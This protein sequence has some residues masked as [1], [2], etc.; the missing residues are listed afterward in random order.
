MNTINQPETLEKGICVLVDGGCLNNNKPVSERSMYGSMTVFYNGKQVASRYFV[1]I[2]HIEEMFGEGDPK[3]IHT[4]DITGDN[5]SNNYAEVAMLRTALRYAWQL[6]ARMGFDEKEIPGDIT[7]MSDSEWALSIITGA[8]KLKAQNQAAY[9]N[10][11]ADVNHYNHA[12]VQHGC[13]V[14]FQHV[15]NLWVKSVL[16]H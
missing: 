11:L 12:L 6:V 5:A 7:V 1:N 2:E 8:Y 16:G 15:N 13:D 9:N 4:F 14:I 3:L 10:L